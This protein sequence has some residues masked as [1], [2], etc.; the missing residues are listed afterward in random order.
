MKTALALVLLMFVSACGSLLPKPPPAPSFYALTGT[1]AG[2]SATAAATTAASA[3]A[4]SPTLVVNPPQA[5]A[6]YDSARIIYIRQPHQLQYFAQSEWVDTPARMLA[7]LLVA[8]L[9]GSGAFKAVVMSP[10]A[11]TGDLR[12]DT[13]IVRLAQRFDGAG[14]STVHLTVRATLVDNPTRKVR[15]TREFDAQVAAGAD[16]YSGV[17]A[18]NGAVQTVL[19]AVAAFVAESAR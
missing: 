14:G 15:G 11:A 10:S 16:A 2:G 4:N 17:V 8:A 1:A 9:S 3:T 7:P 13:E 6:G 5:A 18:A 19:L 12:L